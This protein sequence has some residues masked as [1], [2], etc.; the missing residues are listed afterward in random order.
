M[1][2]CAHSSTCRKRPDILD[3]VESSES[4]EESSDSEDVDDFTPKLNALIE[5]GVLQVTDRQVAIKI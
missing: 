1:Y 2:L 3:S 4:D 5:S